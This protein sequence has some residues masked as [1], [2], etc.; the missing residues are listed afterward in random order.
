MAKGGKRGHPCNVSQRNATIEPPRSAESTPAS[1]QEAIVESE[2]EMGVQISTPVLETLEPQSPAQVSII[3][4]YASIVDPNEE[5]PLDGNFPEFIE[6]INDKDVLVW[7]QVRYEWKP[8]RCSY[9]QMLS[10]DVT[11]CKKKEG[12]TNCYSYRVQ[13]GEVNSIANSGRRDTIGWFHSS[14]QK[15]YS[16]VCHAVTTAYNNQPRNKPMSGT[17]FRK[18]RL[19]KKN[20]HSIVT[21]TFLWWKWMHNF[22]HNSKGRI[23]IAWKP[24]VYGVELVNMTE[25]LIH[26]HITQLQRNM[27]FFIS[28]VYGMNQDNQR[29]KLW[30][31]MQHIA[32]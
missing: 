1:T 26:Y 3:S 21:R 5:M 30:H 10:Y 16:T 17:A 15:G 12:K 32:T 28:F 13:Y 19:R 2:V 6:F 29:Q 24:N 20:V 22:S 31:D 14:P 8:I 23:W 4:S 27:K 7:Q 9:C 25:Q 18:Q 11:I